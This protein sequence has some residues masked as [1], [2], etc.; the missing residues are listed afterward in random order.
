[1]WRTLKVAVGCFLPPSE[2]QQ[3]RPSGKF[4]FYWMPV[5]FGLCECPSSSLKAACL[6]VPEA[7][8]I[9]T[10]NCACTLLEEPSGQTPAATA[11]QKCATERIND[12]YG[13]KGSTD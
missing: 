3:L 10:E 1:M 9:Q 2:F 7:P 5:E 11:I 13:T 8:L 4:G 12:V 6:S